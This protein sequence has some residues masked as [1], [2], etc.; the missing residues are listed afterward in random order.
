MDGCCGIGSDLIALASCGDAVGFE[1]NPLRAAITAWNLSISGV[2]AEVRNGNSLDFIGDFDQVFCDPA[3][4]RAGVRFSEIEH[5]APNP[6]EILARAK[7]SAKV[8]L[9]LSPML[10]NQT[11]LELG[12][13]VLFVSFRGECRE[14]LCLR[15]F[16]R[17]PGVHAF[18]LESGATVAGESAPP[19]TDQPSRYIFDVDPAALRANASGAFCETYNLKSLGYASGYLT[20]DRKVDS[21]W[22]RSFE[23]LKSYPFSPSRPLDLVQQLP[24]AAHDYLAVKSRVPGLDTSQLTK[25]LRNRGL[26]GADSAI[27]FLFIMRK[28]GRALLCRPCE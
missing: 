12:E 26:K 8:A 4:R 6:L 19:V 21:P 17:R 28:S 18:H 20:G 13:T 9:K 14:A 24:A 10:P 1:L 15:G 3:R 2:Q 11:L 23:F 27:V 22:L 25:L 16:D 5:F 7:R